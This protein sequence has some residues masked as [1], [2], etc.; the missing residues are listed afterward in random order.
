M[1]LNDNRLEVAERI[2]KPY[3]KEDPFDAAAVRMLAELAARIGRNP[4]CRDL[5]R[6]AVELSPGWTA[7]KP[8]S[9]YCSGEWGGPPKRWSC[10]TRSSRRSRRSG[11]W[12]L[13][14]A[15]LGRLGDFEE[16]HRDVRSVLARA[17]QQPSVWM[18]YGHMLKTIGR[19]D[20]GIAA[21]RK[22][23]AF[24]RR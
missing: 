18:S 24:G 13:K 7:P 19:L 3:L 4:R 8:I 11:H 14:A 23:I 12:N 17:P 9:R 16:A 6:R 22:A 10:L 5:L 2:L 1:A 21:Y 20:E 15:T